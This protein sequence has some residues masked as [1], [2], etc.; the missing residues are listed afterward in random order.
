L[1]GAFWTARFRHAEQ[2]SLG[3]FGVAN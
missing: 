2:Y 1:G 3:T